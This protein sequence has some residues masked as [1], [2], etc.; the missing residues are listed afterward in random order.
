M[1]LN[2]QKE[3]FSNA[4]VSAIASAGGLTIAKPAP[5]VESVDFTLGRPDSASP[6]LDLQLKCSSTAEIDGDKIPFSLPMKNYDELRTA[7]TMVPRILVCVLV[8][9][10][11]EQWLELKRKRMLLRHCA[12]W[13]SLEGAAAVDNENSKTVHIPASQQFTVNAAHDLL[14]VVAAGDRP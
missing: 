14:D 12:Y 5:D 6:R 11:P 3:H 8:P 2:H 7:R 4:F 10:A 1:D 9:D 13:M